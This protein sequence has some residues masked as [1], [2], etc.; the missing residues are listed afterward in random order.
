MLESA[1][2]RPPTELDGSPL[3]LAVVG[4]LPTVMLATWVPICWILADQVAARVARS[5]GWRVPLARLA[6]LENP[7][8]WVVPAP[9]TV[10]SWSVWTRSLAVKRCRSSRAQPSSKRFQ[11]A[12]SV[13][14]RA[15]TASVTGKTVARYHGWR[16][17]T[18][19]IRGAV[20]GRRTGRPWLRLV[21]PLM[22]TT[23]CCPF[24]MAFEFRDE[25]LQR[26]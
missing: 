6:A 14:S 26:C 24:R 4:T 19:W 21:F 17:S 20:A 11:D 3:V 22:A 25:F 7:G 18:L 13:T 2:T 15:M 9:V 23:V 8:A 16:R 10:A 1:G 12:S 5:F